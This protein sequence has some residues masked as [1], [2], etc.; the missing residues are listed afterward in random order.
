MGSA[1]AKVSLMIGGSGLLLRLLHK[2]Q[3]Y[4]R[5]LLAVGKN[6]CHCRFTVATFPLLVTVK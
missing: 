6:T 1:A 5:W 3:A 2:R 4:G